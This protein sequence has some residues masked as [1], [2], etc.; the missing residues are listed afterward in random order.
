MKVEVR[1]FIPS[2][3]L[4][5]FSSSA[6]F[7]GE[8]VITNQEINQ[9]Q[10]LP[11]SDIL[12]IYGSTNLQ[13]NKDQTLDYYLR[14]QSS[15][16]ERYKATL[17]VGADTASLQEH[18]ADEIQEKMAEIKGVSFRSRVQIPLPKYNA[19]MAGFPLLDEYCIRYDNSDVVK[20]PMRVGFGSGNLVPLDYGFVEAA[21]CINTAGWLYPATQ[22]EAVNL[23]QSVA[24]PLPSNPMGTIPV[25][26]A[27]T[28][29]SC[30][31]ETDDQVEGA[32][33]GMGYKVLK[34]QAVATRGWSQKPPGQ[35]LTVRLTKIN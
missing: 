2:I 6:A 23:V 26:I 32:G 13:K 7:A 21:I 8:S 29:N 35:T 16:Y 18:A 9:Y 1:L 10:V 14:S 22:D 25:I 17:A 30:Q 31:A 28:V 24:S 33:M 19:S 20:K 27:F 12:A 5:L 34:C 4:A 11:F 15:T 3:L